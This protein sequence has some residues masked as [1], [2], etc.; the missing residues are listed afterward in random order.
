MKDPQMDEFQEVRSQISDIRSAM[1]IS[2]STFR[3]I[4]AADNFRTLFLLSGIFSLVL[5]LLYQVMI[6][7][8]KSSEAIPKYMHIIF[9]VLIFI[10]WSILIAI[11]IKTSIRESKKLGLS[12]NFFNMAKKALSTKIWIAISP[13]LIFMIVIPIKYI[14]SFTA[15]EY[16]PYYGIVL[17][18]MLNMIGVMIREVEYSY[19][20]GWM[21]LSGAILLFAFAIPVHIAFALIFTPG[22][23]LF[24]L[25]NSYWRT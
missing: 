5:P 7:V 21:I 14:S 10:C 12:T 9:Y 22:C 2:S 25:A 4:Y 11:R 23:F 20:G 8:Y 16:L 6:W 13:A 1:N 3:L 24:V 18:L 17:G 15:V 19:A